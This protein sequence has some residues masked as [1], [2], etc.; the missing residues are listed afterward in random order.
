MFDSQL[1][2][3]YDHDILFYDIE[4]MTTNGEFATLKNEHAT[5]SLIQMRHLTNNRSTKTNIV[6]ALDKY[7][8]NYD[9]AHLNKLYPNTSI[10]HFPNEQMMCTHFL[11]LLQRFTCT[12]LVIGFNASGCLVK[13]HTKEELE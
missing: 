5:I 12:T 6:F 10:N 11:Q 4:A 8:N 3:S 1:E 2:Y 13:S 7:K 9:F